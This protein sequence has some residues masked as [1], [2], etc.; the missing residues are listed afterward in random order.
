MLTVHASKGL[1]APIVF[2]P[3]TCGGPDRRHEPKLMRLSSPRPARSA[4]LGLG[5]E[6]D[7]GRRR[8]RR[9]AGR[10]ARGSGGRTSPP[11]LCRHDPRGSA[12]H[13][14]RLRDFEAPPVGLLVRSRPF[15]PCRRARRSARAVSRGRDDP[16]IRRGPSR[17]GPG[18]NGS[19]ARA[20][21]PCPAG[22]SPMRRPRRSLPRSTLRAPAALARATA[23]GRSRDGLRMLCSRCCPN[24]RRNDARARR[25]PTSSVG[26]RAC[27]I[28][29][30][31]ARLK[32]PGGDRRAGAEPC[33]LAR[34]PERGGLGG[35]SASA[36]AARPAL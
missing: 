1:E 23:S 31:G 11:A 8:G 21:T 24:S 14:R 2:L 4:G 35:T 13:R 10:G 22:S 7:R 36:R 5:Q 17:R 9:S 16:A 28:G 6:V 34:L 19:A 15:G 3:D 18:R 27:R 26:R 29:A 12:P 30:R 25:R 33:S 20:A 32:G